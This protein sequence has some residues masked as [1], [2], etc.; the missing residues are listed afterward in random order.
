M[1]I[2]IIIIIVIRYLLVMKGAPERILQRCTSI[3]ID[4]KERPMTQDWKD[5]FESAYMELGGDF[6]KN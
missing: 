2:I 5:A 1:I 4:G 3:I 6:L